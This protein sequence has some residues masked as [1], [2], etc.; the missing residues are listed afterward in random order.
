VLRHRL[1]TSFAAEAEGVTTDTVVERLLAEISPNESQALA[2][3]RLPGVI[4]Q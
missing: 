1:V 4:S 2:D 3:G